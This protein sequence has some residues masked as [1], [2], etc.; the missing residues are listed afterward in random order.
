LVLNNQVSKDEYFRIKDKIIE[1]NYFRN[2]MELKFNELKQK[3]P[4]KSSNNI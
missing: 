2:E 4:K 1:D 3:T